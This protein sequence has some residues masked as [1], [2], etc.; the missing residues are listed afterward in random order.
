LT[1]TT[2]LEFYIPF[3]D[4]VN[5][6][7]ADGDAV[8]DISGNGHNFTGN[9]GANNTGLT[10]SV[11]GYL[12]GEQYPSGN[13]AKESWQNF[14]NAAG[15]ANTIIDDQDWGK[16]FLD[17]ASPGNGPVKNIGPTGVTRIFTKQIWRGR[18]WIF[19]C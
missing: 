10:W 11:S 3:N 5:D 7:S 13:D 16:L 2:N 8:N 17:T 18:S 14:D 6:T 9:D 12:W 15:G 4:G 19:C 1:I